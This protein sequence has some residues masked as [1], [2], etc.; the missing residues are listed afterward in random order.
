MNFDKFVLSVFN[1]LII[2][3]LIFFI[4][5]TNPSI[6]SSFPWFSEIINNSKCGINPL[7]STQ[8]Q[9]LALKSSA[10]Q[11]DFI[12]TEIVNMWHRNLVW[13][14]EDNNS[15]GDTFY[16][17]CASG[18]CICRLLG[19]TS[20]KFSLLHSPQISWQGGLL[21]TNTPD[22]VINGIISNN[23]NEIAYVMSLYYSPFTM[24]GTPS[25]GIP[26]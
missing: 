6:V 24:R 11:M 5:V 8:T 2:Y 15:S 1:F 18:L 21:S 20:T 22:M 13:D 3:S 17:E 9:T 16:S 14:E 10:P 12:S 25:D 26:N 19:V 23:F 7:W 4:G